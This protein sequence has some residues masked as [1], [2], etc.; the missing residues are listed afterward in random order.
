MSTKHHHND[1]TQVNLTE[2]F[3][4]IYRFLS[5][6]PVFF[7]PDTSKEHESGYEAEDFWPKV[8][9][10]LRLAASIQ[11]IKVTTFP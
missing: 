9:E 8:S 4:L 2:H 7:D 1:D 3:T 5:L 6:V 10:P 11:E